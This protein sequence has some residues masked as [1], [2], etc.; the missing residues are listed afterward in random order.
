MVKSKFSLLFVVFISIAITSCSDD[1]SVQNTVLNVSDI[2]GNWSLFQI[3]STPVVDL[4]GDANTN[5]NIMA[6]TD[7]FNGM[8][9]NFGTN[10][11]LTVVSSEITF[12]SNADP[13]FDCSLRTDVGSY[14]ISGNDLT[15][16]IPISGNQEIQTV[17]IDVQNNNILSFTLTESQVAQFFSVPSGESFSTITE[18]EFVYE[19]F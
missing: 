15:V 19:K 16:T 8:S 18:L 1:D 3:N 17:V 14:S 11:V 13:S 2:E 10:G 12:D 7:C 4:E 5:P 9:L 6:Q